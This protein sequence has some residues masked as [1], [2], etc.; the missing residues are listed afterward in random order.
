MNEALKPDLRYK[1]NNISFISN[2]RIPVVESDGLPLQYITIEKAQ[3]ICTSLRELEEEV[4]EIISEINSYSHSAKYILQAVKGK[5]EDG[6]PVFEKHL[7]Q[8]Q[9]L[10]G[11]TLHS[12]IS[13][14]LSKIDER[15]LNLRAKLGIDQEAK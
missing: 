11:G 5:A 4:K 3:R 6:D 10:M 8:H 9:R 7:E 2:G 13:K 14:S 12:M 1:K 15:L